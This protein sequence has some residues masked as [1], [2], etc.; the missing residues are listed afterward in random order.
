MAVGVLIA[1][2]GVTESAYRQL[3]EKMFGTYPMPQSDAPD[4]LIIHTAGNTD[5]GWY[6]YDVWESQE[7]FAQFAETKLAP[8]TQELGLPQSAAPQP[9]FFPIEVLEKGP[10]F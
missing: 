3:T 4:G 5:Q 9:Q 7:K 2:E 6:V 8:A 1:G 10:A